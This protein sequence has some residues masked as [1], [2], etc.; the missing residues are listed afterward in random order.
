MEEEEG[1][2]R[3]RGHNFGFAVSLRQGLLCSPS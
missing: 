2:E 1:K 3:E